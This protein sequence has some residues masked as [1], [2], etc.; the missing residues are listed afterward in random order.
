MNKTPAFFRQRMKV[1]RVGQPKTRGESVVKR[2]LN[3]KSFQ[4]C[5]KWQQWSVDPN[6][7]L[8]EIKTLK[9]YVLTAKYAELVKKIVNINKLKNTSAVS[10]QELPETE[11]F[12]DFEAQPSQV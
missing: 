12:Q 4:K 11:P 9:D 7:D 5:Q 1:L 2:S 8:K 3:L 6:L 10:T